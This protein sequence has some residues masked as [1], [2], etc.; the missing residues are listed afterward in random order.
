[1]RLVLRDERELA[2]EV[3]DHPGHCHLVRV[4]QASC[5]SVPHGLAS[6]AAPQASV[7]VLWY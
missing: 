2:R 1:V 6:S 4:L 7:V 5:R 3:A